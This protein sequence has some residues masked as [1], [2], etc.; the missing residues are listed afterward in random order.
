MRS[1]DVGVIGAGQGP[2]GGAGGYEQAIE[3]AAQ[4]EG[5]VS[6]PVEGEAAAD[7][8][9]GAVGTAHPRSQ[10]LRAATMEADL[11]AR[12]DA[13]AVPAAEA[14]AAS[15]TGGARLSDEAYEAVIASTA[16]SLF[17]ERMRGMY[18]EE[19]AST[20]D[21]ADKDG[22]RAQWQ[23]D[24]QNGLEGLIP[25]NGEWKTEEVRD[26]YAAG[27]P[28]HDAS[29]REVPLDDVRVYWLSMYTEIDS[30]ALGQPVVM[31][32]HSG[33]VLEVGDTYD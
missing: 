31:D 29:G 6:Q 17:A 11:H 22:L 33:E 23:D 1:G 26:N 16:K 8:G 7:S 3:G 24:L 15:A 12:L 21:P 5:S 2:I 25:D 20:P 14:G 4:V 28:Y 18:E 13:P 9:A 19:I 32:R 27:K 30:V 10:D